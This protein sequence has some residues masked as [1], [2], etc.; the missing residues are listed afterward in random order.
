MIYN[1]ITWS[2]LVVSVVFVVLL[3]LHIKKEATRSTDEICQSVA[4][5][6]EATTEVIESFSGVGKV[7][8]TLLTEEKIRAVGN[9]FFAT[10]AKAVAEGVAE[11][12]QKRS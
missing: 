1:I 5:V 12:L 11:G 2:P 3:Y 6:T 10:M 9:A 7:V 8:E 4:K